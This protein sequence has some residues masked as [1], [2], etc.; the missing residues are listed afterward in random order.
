MMSDHGD[1]EPS[2]ALPL[3]SQRT[4]RLFART[5][6]ALQA[7][8]GRGRRSAN[9]ATWLEGDKRVYRDP[10]AGRSMLRV[11]AVRRPDGPRQGQG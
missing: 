9:R 2:R 1:F 8:V 11:R 7:T 6:A 10:G 5:A 4:I 3:T